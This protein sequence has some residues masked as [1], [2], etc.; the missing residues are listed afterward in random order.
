MQHA[1]EVNEGYCRG[2]PT[3]DLLASRRSY[4]TNWHQSVLI[5]LEAKIYN[6][7]ENQEDLESALVTSQA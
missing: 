4:Y 3:N 6:S 7:Q 2:R 5:T 1:L